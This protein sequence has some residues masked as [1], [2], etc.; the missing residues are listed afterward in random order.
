M[1][2]AVGSNVR[3]SSFFLHLIEVVNHGLKIS[4]APGADRKLNGARYKIQAG[5][6][7]N[8]AD[9]SLDQLVRGGGPEDRHPRA[10]TGVAGFDQRRVGASE[11]Q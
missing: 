10:S 6:G 7:R 2:E 5:R 4:S 3:F 1:A 9:F 11:D 8:P